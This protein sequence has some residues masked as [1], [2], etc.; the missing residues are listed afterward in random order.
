MLFRAFA[1]E[2]TRGLVLSQIDV[3]VNSPKAGKIVELLAKEEDTVTV[4]QDLF[5]LDT[6]GGGGGTSL[7]LIRG[8]SDNDYRLSV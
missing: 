1:R 4:G 5:K 7:G 2:L 3:S 8:R 6:D